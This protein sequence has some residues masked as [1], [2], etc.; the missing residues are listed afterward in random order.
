M[1]NRSTGRLGDL[2]TVREKAAGAVP[3][4]TIPDFR[5][6]ISVKRPERAFIFDIARSIEK[7]EGDAAI[8]ANSGAYKSGT[9][10]RDEGDERDG[11]RFLSK[12]Q[13]LPQSTRRDAE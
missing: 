1:R 4:N 11:S 3:R 5:F 13:V 2:A 12:R 7:G 10:N 9:F 6:Q 8:S